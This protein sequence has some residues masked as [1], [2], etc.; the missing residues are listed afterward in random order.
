MAVTPRRSR[1]L[2]SR[3][4]SW[5]RV[6]MAA[7][8]LVALG[9]FV[10][11]QSATDRIRLWTGP[12]FSPLE[13]L[14]GDWALALK[15]RISR[16]GA[17]SQPEGPPL[18]EQVESLQGAMAQAAAILGEYDRRVRDLARIR[19]GLDGLPCR[20]VPARLI[21]PEVAGG[22]AEARLGEG[23]DKGIRRAAAVIVGRIDRGARE[24]IQRGEPVLT[25]AGLVGIV[26]DVGPVT[27]TVRL[28]T[29]PRTSLM[30]QV[31]TL[32][33][34]QW[35]AGPE[36][37]ARGSDDGT[38][39]SVQGIPRNSD[40]APGDFVVTS[41]SRESPLPPYLILGRVLR[42]NAKPAALF[43]DLVVEPRVVPAEAHEVFVLSPETAGR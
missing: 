22:R 29:D 3:R 21:P 40:V 16:P 7:L 14:T 42:C 8:P 20:L 32:R 10:M 39:L 26:D 31:I 4:D 33:N 13:N 36:G 6:M 19:Q 9:L 11:P 35:R 30:V 38:T 27:S 23:A 12:I 2:S 37:V 25:A 43:R 15:E 5:M 18:Q 1:R 34:G 28:V 41:P 17:A 24:A